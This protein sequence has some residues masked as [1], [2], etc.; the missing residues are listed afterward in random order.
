MRESAGRPLKRG[1]LAEATGINPET[2]R[3]YEDRGLIRK[4][5]RSANG[6]RQYGADTVRRLA[7][8][9]EIKDLGFTLREIEQLLALK[10]RSAITCKTSASVA[11]GKIGE[12]DEKI[13][14]LKAMR[15]RLVTFRDR[16]L[17]E[18]DK[19]CAAFSL[20]GDD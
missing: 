10:A 14:S 6:Y 2:L 19:C 1:E 15:K 8:I 3:F 11:N 12:I 9:R 17:I 16:C 20:I 18:Q 7:F 4:P 5:L 13:A